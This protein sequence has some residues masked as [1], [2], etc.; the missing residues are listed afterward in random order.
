VFIIAA[1]IYIFGALA[2][3]LLGSG[4]NNGG[5]MVSNMKPTKRLSKY[6]HHHYLPSLRTCHPMTPTLMQTHKNNANFL[7]RI[8]CKCTLY[9][10]I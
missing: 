5:Q 3:V 4:R 9:E 8:L 10:N 7:L 1:E 6:P 2:Y